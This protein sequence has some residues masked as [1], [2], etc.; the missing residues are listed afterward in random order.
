MGVDAERD[1]A[2]DMWG[3][4]LRSACADVELCDGIGHNQLFGDNG[5]GRVENELVPASV[6]GSSV[7]MELL[8]SVEKWHCSDSFRFWIDPLVSC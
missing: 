3:L 7:V 8:R 6:L 5:S 2:V 4:E 1:E